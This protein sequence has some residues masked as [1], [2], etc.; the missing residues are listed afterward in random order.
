[1]AAAGRCN[2]MQVGADKASF[3]LFGK[4]NSWHSRE[5]NVHFQWRFAH[6]GDGFY[7]HS[8]ETG[9]PK[10][11][12]M[13][14]PLG[15]PMAYELD[16]FVDMARRAGLKVIRFLPGAWCRDAYVHSYLDVFVLER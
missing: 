12:Y 11:H 4:G 7:T 1:M 8:D 3:K 9:A 6:R 10:N 16:A 2:C 15:D 5:N 14:D 13:A